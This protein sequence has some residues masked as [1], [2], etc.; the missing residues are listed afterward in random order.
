MNLRSEG[1]S[2]RGLLGDFGLLLILF[3]AFRVM[4]LLAYQPFLVNGV[5]RGISTGGDRVYHYE[6]SSL[7]DAG[8]WP[9][10]DWWSEFPPLWYLTTTSIHALLGS[11]A[12]YDNWSL[13]VGAIMITSEAG[14]LVLLRK[15]GA[16]LHNSATG[17]ALAWIYAVLALPGVHM[18]WNFDT[19]VTFT[20]LLGIWLLIIQKDMRS[21]VVVAIGALL[22]FIPFLIFG[23]VLRFRSSARAARYVGVA[24]A[25]FALAYLPLFAVNSSNT[26]VSL[27]AQFG[28]PS[29]QSI[30]ALIDGNYTTGNFGSVESHLDPTR[31]NEGVGDRNP[32]VVPSWLRLGVAALLG[33]VVFVRT[34][35]FDDI[36]LVAFVGVTLLLFYLQAQGFSPQW[37]TQIIPLMLLVYPTRDGAILAIVLSL[38]A[39][40][41]YPFIFIRMGDTGGVVTGTMFMPWALIVIARTVILAGLAYGFYRKLLEEPV[42]VAD[43]S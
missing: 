20:L 37:L 39:F 13:L 33:L 5:E 32:A 6:L 4:L 9:F 3:I 15:L 2:V 31:V 14:I 16:R 17:Q 10:R 22:K 42:P 40:V 21:A 38:L 12:T 26:L 19:L 23:A 11:S 1:L 18:W 27:T 25:L 30:W 7:E 36:G 24:L 41:E 28:K 8:L 29:Y 34:R 35:R 43:M